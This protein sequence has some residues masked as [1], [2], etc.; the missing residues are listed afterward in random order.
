MPGSDFAGFVED[1]AARNQGRYGIDHAEQEGEVPG[2]NDADQGEGDQLGARRDGGYRAVAGCFVLDQFARKAG[3]AVGHV[4]EVV[5]FDVGD[6]YPAGVCAECVEDRLAVV[7]D[8]V[9]EGV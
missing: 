1:C 2:G 8:G 6:Q 5:D 7:L 4:T 9:G 3:H